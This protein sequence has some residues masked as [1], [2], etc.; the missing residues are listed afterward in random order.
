MLYMKKI[1]SVFIVIY[2]SI[3]V[4]DLT[5]QDRSQYNYAHNKNNSDPI[6]SG[7][8]VIQGE[9]LSIPYRVEFKN[10]TTLINNTVFLPFTE[11]STLPEC[12]QYYQIS[13]QVILQ[14]EIKKKYFWLR[15]SYGTYLAKDSIIYTYENHPLISSMKFISPME[16]LGVEFI[17]GDRIE[18]LGRDYVIL[19]KDAFIPGEERISMT[20]YGKDNIRSALKNRCMVLFRDD[21]SIMVLDQGKTQTLI[22]IAYDI[23]LLK[24]RIE[25]G[26]DRIANFL[27]DRGLA[28]DIV[29]NLDSWGYGFMHLPGI[30]NRGADLF[31]DCDRVILREHGNLYPQGGPAYFDVDVWEVVDTLMIVCEWLKNHDRY[32][33]IEVIS[34]SGE[35]VSDS[36]S[37]DPPFDISTVSDSAVGI[38]KIK[39]SAVNPLENQ[40]YVTITVGVIFEPLLDIYIDE[41]DIRFFPVPNNPNGLRITADIHYFDKY[42]SSGFLSFF[43]KC[44]LGDPSD[45]IQ[46]GW[47]AFY[48]PKGST[49]LDFYFNKRRCEGVEPCEV[50]IIIDCN[51]E[52]KEYDEDNNVVSKVITFGE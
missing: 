3:M 10:D 13:Q 40:H 38:W 20:E 46:V 9:M 48:K 11:D 15:D 6:L 44:Y 37:Y 42:Y 52:V 43:A 35:T 25:T 5:A 45:S 47:G 33:R 16:D 30:S 26:I 1:L 23:V 17:N 39:V 49:L 7:Y 32:V 14:K 4:F 36:S 29:K 34:P 31:P 12:V 51:N 22:E 2:F 8:I 41:S 18:M 50:C 19:Y 21:M 27:D 24:C 28:E